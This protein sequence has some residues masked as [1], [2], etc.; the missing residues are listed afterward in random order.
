MS[1]YLEWVGSFVENWGYLAI[2]LGMML[3]NSVG[4]GLIFPGLFIL[5]SGGFYAGIGELNIFFVFFWAYLG[6]LSGDNISY[7]IGRYG[8]IK[9]PFLKKIS[10][11]LDKIEKSIRKDTERFLIFFHFPV[12][13]RM[14]L[15]AFLGILSFRFRKWLILDMIGAFLF[16]STFSLTGYIIGKTTQLLD[17]AIS[18]STYIQWVFFL[19]FVWWFVSVVYTIIKL[20]R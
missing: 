9:V 2:F 5:I 10:P 4:L 7:F 6:V 8:F 14:V 13:S 16:T 3:E 12:Y 11:H 17:T 15:P 1:E 20:F 18:V 19:L